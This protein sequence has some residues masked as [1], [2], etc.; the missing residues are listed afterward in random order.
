MFA[1]GG[2]EDRRYH[3]CGQPLQPSPASAVTPQLGAGRG[4]HR[5]QRGELGLSCW[6]QPMSCPY[7][8]TSNSKRLHQHGMYVCTSSMVLVGRGT[9]KSRLVLPDVLLSRKKPLFLPVRERGYQSHLAGC[10][11]AAPPFWA[12]MMSLW[13]VGMYHPLRSPRCS[14]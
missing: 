14:R 9:Q 7:S 13:A 11:H 5:A 10:S 3:G 2:G 1:L 4:R 8:V 12:G 6:S